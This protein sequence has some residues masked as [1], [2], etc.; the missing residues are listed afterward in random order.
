LVIGQN[1][2][3]IRWFFDSRFFGDCREING[4]TDSHLIGPDSCSDTQERLAAQERIDFVTPSNFR[5]ISEQDHGAGQLRRRP[6][7][8]GAS[9]HG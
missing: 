5:R 1:R 9:S 8:A 4:L 2:L 6:A 7:T 3:S